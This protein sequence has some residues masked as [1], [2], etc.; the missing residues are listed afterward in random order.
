MRMRRVR[1]RIFKSRS[2]IE[3]KIERKNKRTFV[4]CCVCCSLCLG[5]IAPICHVL[6]AIV[7]NSV[8][9]YVYTTVERFFVDFDFCKYIFT[10]FGS[11]SIFSVFSTFFFIFVCFSDDRHA[12]SIFALFAFTTIR[13]LS[14]QFSGFHS[15][16]HNNNNKGL[17]ANHPESSSY[18]IFEMPHSFCSFTFY[19]YS[20]WHYY[21]RRQQQRSD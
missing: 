5:Q 1:A 20:L 4:W 18:H 11:L 14:S 12:T 8:C 7:W 15:F 6:F 16:L 19:L 10:L 21:L 9:V 3:R 2:K 13:Q 17:C